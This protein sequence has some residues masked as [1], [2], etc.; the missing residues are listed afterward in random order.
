M[1]GHLQLGM[2]MTWQT[3]LARFTIHLF[4]AM[5]TNALY[6]F[7][8]NPVSSHGAFFLLVTGRCK[9]GALDF[10]KEEDV[11]EHFCNVC[12]NYTLPLVV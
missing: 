6:D 3:N 11:H 10:L 7:S 1:R 9:G 12:T 2:H 4:K 8:Y 5:F